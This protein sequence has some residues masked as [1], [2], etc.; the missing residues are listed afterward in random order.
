M[1][2]HSEEFG[3]EDQP[4]WDELWTSAHRD[5]YACFYEELTSEFL[6]GRWR[7]I[8]TLSKFLTAATASGSAVAAWTFWAK[9]ETGAAIWATMSGI[10]ALL[11][12]VHTSLGI[13]DRIKEDTLIFAT[14][15]QL[16]LE[17]ER[18]KLEMRIRCHDSLAV[19][20]KEYMQIFSKF[21]KAHSFKR[22]DFFVTKR[23][24]KQ[25]QED[26]NTRLGY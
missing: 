7:S 23:R 5:H 2:S 20:K 16:R 15:Q 26:L 19:Y 11:T 1:P 22:P 18:F 12:L 8:D 4:I 13:S 9:S 6:V 3:P 10:A 17:L 24:E 21:E 25:I 14:F